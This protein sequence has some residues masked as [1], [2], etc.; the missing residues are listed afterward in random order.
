MWVPSP[1]RGDASSVSSVGKRSTGPFSIS[2]SPHLLYGR[3]SGKA[4][5]YAIF[6]F[7]IFL[8]MIFFEVPIF[9]VV[10]TE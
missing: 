3:S 2:T 6:G 8:L 9:I 10:S 4:F 7:S 5:V 1:R